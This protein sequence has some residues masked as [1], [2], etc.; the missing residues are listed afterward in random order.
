MAGAS[1]GDSFSLCA[2]TGHTLSGTMQ[3]CDPPWQ[4]AATLSNMNDSVF[5]ITVVATAAALTEASVWLAAYGL[6]EETVKSFQAGW[7]VL[8]DNLPHRAQARAAG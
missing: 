2:A 3:I 1:E 5:R 6:P 8:L 4:F 7:T